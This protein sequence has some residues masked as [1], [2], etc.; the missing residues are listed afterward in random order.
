VE[1]LRGAWGSMSFKFLSLVFP[2]P[3]TLALHLLKDDLLSNLDFNATKLCFKV[4]DGRED[5]ASVGRGGKEDAGWVS[6]STIP[7]DF[8]VL[9]SS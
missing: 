9:R 8:G 1:R 3:L 6:Y 4:P 7:L 5:L 2:F